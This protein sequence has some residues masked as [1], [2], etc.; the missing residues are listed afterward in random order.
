MYNTVAI[1]NK[2]PN[3]C[4][5]AKCVPRKATDKTVAVNGSKALNIP[6]TDGEIYFVLIKYSK[7][8]NIVQKTIMKAILIIVIIDTLG[9]EVLK[10]KPDSGKLPNSI[11]HPTIN[12][13]SK[14]DNNL[15]GIKV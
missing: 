10:T 14:D 9:A 11:P 15:A 2:P 6:V 13:S 3:N 12:L 7:Y 4:T 8:A 5:G 1:I